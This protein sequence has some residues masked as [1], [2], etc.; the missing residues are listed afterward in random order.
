MKQQNSEKFFNKEEPKTKKNFLVAVVIILILVLAVFFGVNKLNQQSVVYVNDSIG[1]K[2]NLPAGWRVATE[3]SRYMS[4]TNYALNQMIEV[5]CYEPKAGDI[6]SVTSTEEAFAEYKKCLDDKVEEIKKIDEGAGIFERTWEK[7]NSEYIAFTDITPEQEV[8]LLEQIKNGEIM[9]SDLP[10]NH[11]LELYP[12]AK[13]NS[14][15]NESKA[16]Q[17]SRTFLYL[18]DGTK[19]YLMEMILNGFNGI[20]VD[21]PINFLSSIANEKMTSL[22]F[23]VRLSNSAEKAAEIYQSVKT[24]ELS[25]K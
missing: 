12:V 10:V 20:T 5:G 6:E 3:I 1:Y 8:A 15:V 7:S 22:R 25:S 21:V 9:I 17:V 23:I 4:A 11:F 24:L 13:L 18:N 19:S 14:F 16:E 2:I